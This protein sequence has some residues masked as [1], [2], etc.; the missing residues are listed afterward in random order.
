M[1]GIAERVL[2]AELLYRAADYDAAYAALDEAVALFDA[3]PYDE[4]HGWLMSPRQT[5]GALLTEQGRYER[6]MAVYDEDLL[7]FPKNPWALAGLRICCT[8]LSSPR[9]AGVVAA[10]EEA[11]AATD[12]PIG[13]SCAC[14]LSDWNASCLP[15]AFAKWPTAD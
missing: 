10:L 12:V 1:G 6:A 8:K 11:R 13:A 15:A 4:P 14:A 2:A 3:L 5:L 9:L 7:L